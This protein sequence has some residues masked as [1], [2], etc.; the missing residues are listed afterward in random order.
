MKAKPKVCVR[1]NSWLARLAARALGFDH[2]AM[3]FGHTIHLYNTSIERFFARRGWVLHELRHVSQYERYG[4]LGFLLR[5]GKE[6][7]RKGYFHNAL[8]AEAR[9]S[10]QDYSLLRRYDLSDYA[11]Y[12]K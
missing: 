1:E 2:V 11:G 8:E 7:L 6:Y 3:V 10:E 12:M 4:M 9:D 5:Y